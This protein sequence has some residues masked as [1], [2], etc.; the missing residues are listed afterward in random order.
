MDIEIKQEWEGKCGNNLTKTYE[1]YVDGVL[2]GFSKRRWH[3]IAQADAVRNGHIELGGDLALRLD[4]WAYVN[5]PA[6]F[7]RV[8]KIPASQRQ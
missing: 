1:I 3:A 6:L 4:E 5:D 8:D 2:V 7:S